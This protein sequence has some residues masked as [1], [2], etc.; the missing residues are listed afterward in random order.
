MADTGKKTVQ[1]VGST[2]KNI[3]ST[4]TNAT[5]AMV[6]GTVNATGKV[7][8]AVSNVGK[9]AAGIATAGLGVASAAT[10]K[11]GKDAFDAYGEYEQLAGGIETLF[12]ENSPA[13]QAIK[14]YA[15]NAFSTV[16]MSANDYMQT[17]TDFSATLLQKLDPTEAADKAD[18]ALRQMSDNANKMG[19]AIG[20]VEDAYRG[21]AKSN[22]TMLDNLKLG[23]GGN[24]SELARLINDAGVLGDVIADEK[25][26]WDVASF[27]KI[28]D[29][30]GVIQ[31]RLGMAGVSQQEALHTIQGS[32]NMTK[33]AW[34]NLLAGWANPDA[35]LDK[36]TS[37]LMESVDAVQQNALPAIERI[38][39]S[40]GEAV[41]KTAPDIAK[42]A[43]DLITKTAPTLMRAAASLMSNV[44]GVI[45]NTLPGIVDSGVAAIAGL[46][47][48]SDSGGLVNSTIN[49]AERLA[50]TVRRYL[51]T[52]VAKTLNG[53]K[54]NAPAVRTGI[55]NV[56]KTLLDTFEDIIK[57]GDT[58][59]I[60]ETVTNTIIDVIGLLAQHAPTFITAMADIWKT[61]LTT[62]ID[63]VK[64]D[65]QGF[66]NGVLGI[67]SAIVGGVASVAGELF[68]AVGELIGTILGGGID[69]ADASTTA[70]QLGTWFGGAIATVAENIDP[71]TIANTATSIVTLITSALSPAIEEGLPAI[72]TF[73]AGL[74]TAFT[75][76]ENSA[77]L[78]E[79]GNKLVESVTNGM[80]SIAESGNIQ[81]IRTNIANAIENL[82]GENGLLSKDNLDKLFSAGISLLESLSDGLDEDTETVLTA[83]GHVIDNII[84]GLTSNDNASR[85]LWGLVSFLT[86]IVTGA[87]NTVGGVL[88]AGLRE[89]FAPLAELSGEEDM[90]K[91]RNDWNDKF[92]SIKLKAPSGEQLYGMSIW[93]QKELGLLDQTGYDIRKGKYSRNAGDY[94]YER[95]EY[96]DQGRRG[97]YYN[98]ETGEEIDRD[99][100]FRLELDGEVINETT[101]AKERRK[102]AARGY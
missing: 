95:T 89:I 30:I 2:V 81:T 71:E 22:A 44:G 101:A 41:T 49:A 10:V 65:P 13:S 29:A 47:D 61:V 94:R 18:K 14:A 15:D 74:T 3:A 73:I 24:Q 45:L 42:R 80:Q 69:A 59:G 4:V 34:E 16:Q 35:D 90:E 21:L 85:L 31:E 53:V 100:I 75:N 60:V 48:E 66:T 64:E 56:V 62:A 98:I 99:I 79:A 36:L 88:S 63:R 92:N 6:R 11:L 20:S 84:N 54:A 40:M 38:L 28:I 17:V 9:V 7:V 12:G 86:N 43:G 23:Y 76:E 1:A 97:V 5:E 72:A 8:E 67:L 55:V 19:T 82:T 68:P 102:S 87:L 91:W 93:A 83:C 32:I 33:A 57:S 39:N 37:N 52:I 50:G 70:Q 27:D 51:P 46:I 96:D 25:N 78:N 77:K 58:S 26:V